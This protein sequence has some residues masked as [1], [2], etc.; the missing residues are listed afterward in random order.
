[1]ALLALV[2]FITAY[3]VTVDRTS[4]SVIFFT[5]IGTS[6]PPIEATLPLIFLAVAAIMAGPGEL[7]ARCFHELPRLDAYRYDLLSAELALNRQAPDEALALLALPDSSLPPSLVLRRL[8]LTARAQQAL[9]DRFAAARTRAVLDRSLEGAD[10]EN[11]RTEIVETLA[12]LDAATLKQ[13]GAELPPTDLLRP[14]IERALRRQG[15][16]LPL[17][18]GALV[19]LQMHG[20]P[21]FG[22]GTLGDVLLISVVGACTAVPLLSFAYA[23]RHLRFTTLGLLQ[24]LAPTSGHHHG[25]RGYQIYASTCNRHGRGGTAL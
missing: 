11:N 9:G 7:V 13:R 10:R 3:P 17:A 22:A 1:M 21:V 19:W 25:N 5:S 24:F 15:Q 8:E 6:G 23:A 16:V 4:S 18:L 2:G 20:T 14:W 12:A